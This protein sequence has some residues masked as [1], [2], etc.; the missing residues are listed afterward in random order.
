MERSMP[1]SIREDGDMSLR[2][3]FAEII[4]PAAFSP[5][6][7]EMSDMKMRR[8]TALEKADRILAFRLSLD[9]LSPED[10]QGAMG[11]LFEALFCA[12]LGPEDGEG[13]H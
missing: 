12:Q 7:A 13:M 3:K 1:R 4:D 2:E 10:M 11:E 5:E 9:D 6:L 8:E